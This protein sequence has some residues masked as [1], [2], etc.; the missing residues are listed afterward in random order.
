MIL[1]KDYGKIRPTL[2]KLQFKIELIVQCYMK[3]IVDCRIEQNP[4]SF[5]NTYVK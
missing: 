5:S 2:E 3:L 1:R 4:F